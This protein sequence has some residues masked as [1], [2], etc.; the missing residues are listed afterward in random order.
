MVAAALA[1]DSARV[2]DSQP[3]VAAA[4]A[5]LAP[6]AE[7]DVLAFAPSAAGEAE[8]GAAAPAHGCRTGWRRSGSA[9]ADEAVLSPLRLRSRSCGKC[10]ESCKCGEPARRRR[11]SYAGYTDAGGYTDSAVSA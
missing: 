10:G 9:A 4:A 1:P 8:A 5:M 11:G 3:S 6:A 7:E 2:M